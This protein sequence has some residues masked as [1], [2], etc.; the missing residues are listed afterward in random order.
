VTEK[1]IKARQI[2]QQRK[3]AYQN[4][5]NND[6]VFLQTVLEDLSK[7]C[8]ANKTCVVPGSDQATYVSEGRREVWLRIR[9]FLDQDIDQLYE[10]YGE[11]KK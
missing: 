4:V 3:I 10:T 9:D 2:L 8:R 6:N 5:F 1:E 11:G 7:F